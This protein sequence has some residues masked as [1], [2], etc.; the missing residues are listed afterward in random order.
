[1]A[2]KKWYRDGEQIKTGTHIYITQQEPINQEQCI[3]YRAKHL[4]LISEHFGNLP[5]EGEMGRPEEV[6]DYRP[7]T[8]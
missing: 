4:H 3:A 6:W 7:T 8:G 5:H 2:E 1:M